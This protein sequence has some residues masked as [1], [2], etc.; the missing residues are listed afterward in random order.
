MTTPPE[1]P[2]P[3]TVFFS[4][5]HA[6]EPLR[7]ELG[8][9]LHLMERQ[10][11][12][13]SWHDRD[14]TAGQEW[15]TAIDTHLD[16]AS[17]ILLLVSADFLASDYCT[18]V[19]MQRAMARHDNGEAVVIPIILRD[20]DWH[21]ADFGRLQALPKDARPITSWANQDEAF[22]DV[23]RGIRRAVAAMRARPREV[24]HPPPR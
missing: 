20:V 7:D 17:I 1:S 14:I 9:H 15:A 16:T 5:A 18:S 6:D 2:S 4:Y 13:A 8:K 19:E 12:I 11:L 3:L 21:S 22:A 23:A 10:G 24:L